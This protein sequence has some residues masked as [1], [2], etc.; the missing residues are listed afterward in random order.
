MDNLN[1]K[2]FEVWTV[3]ENN[4]EEIEFG[5]VMLEN[6]TYEEAY[7]FA[8]DNSIESKLILYNTKSDSSELFEDGCCMN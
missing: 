7:Y 3:K 4:G 5:K 6:A 1:E 2:V 8:R